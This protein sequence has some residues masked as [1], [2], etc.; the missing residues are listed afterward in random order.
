M[1]N[2]HYHPHRQRVEREVQPGPRPRHVARRGPKTDGL[3]TFLWREY[4]RTSYV[5]VELEL[6]QALLTGAEAQREQALAAI[7]DGLAEL[8]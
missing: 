2:G 3:A 1:L 7:S 5:G 8:L 4:L 6:S